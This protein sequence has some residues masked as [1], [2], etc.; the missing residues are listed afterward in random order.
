MI[1]SQ[2]VKL[3]PQSERPSRTNRSRF[4][5]TEYQLSGI[6]ILLRPK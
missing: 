3:L 1:A 4:V 2:L 5:P 6:W